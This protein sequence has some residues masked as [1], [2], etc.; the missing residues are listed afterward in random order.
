[1]LSIATPLDLMARPNMATLPYALG[2]T[3]TTNCSQPV[4]RTRYHVIVSGT[5]G[6]L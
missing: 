1:V 3:L 6:W 5:A 2:D 4:E